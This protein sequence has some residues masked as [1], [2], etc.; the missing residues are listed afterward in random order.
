[1]RFWDSSALMALLAGQPASQHLSALM[2]SDGDAAVWWGTRIELA[3]GADRMYRDGQL[4][5]AGLSALLT[6]ADRLVNGA[7]EVQPS[8]EVR[9]AALRALRVHSLRAADCLQL[10]AA[11]VWAEH[12]PNGVGFVCLDQRLRDAAEKEGFLVLP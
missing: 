1:M 10:A 8:E 5:G 7:D 6:A 12:N 2:S 9:L 3:S 4:D 11:L